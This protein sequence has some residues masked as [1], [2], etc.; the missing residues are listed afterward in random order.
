MFTILGENQQVLAIVLHD[1]PIIVILEITLSECYPIIFPFSEP[2]GDFHNWGVPQNLWCIM[3]N[4]N[5]A[6][7]MTR[8]TP[9]LGN[10]HISSIP[11]YCPPKRCNGNMIG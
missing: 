4:P 2:V 1:D 8:G 7:I 9:I 5:L 3:E 6:W 10:H 11:T